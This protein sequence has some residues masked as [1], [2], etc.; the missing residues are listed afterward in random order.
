[1]LERIGLVLITP[2]SSTVIRTKHELHSFVASLLICHIVQYLGSRKKLISSSINNSLSAHCVLSEL[3]VSHLKF[4]K[5]TL[6][7]DN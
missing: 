2:W 7:I 5:P 6:N 3:F 1:M 4:A